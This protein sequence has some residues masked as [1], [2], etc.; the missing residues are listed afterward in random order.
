MRTYKFKLYNSDK[1]KYLSR[2]IDI[3]AFVWNHTVALQRKYYKLFGKYASAAKIQKHYTKLKKTG[4]YRFWD[5]LG[6]QA[7][8]EVVQRVDRSYRAFF[9]YKR[10]KTQLRKSPPKFKKKTRY[11]SFTLKQAGYKLD[12]TNSIV[13]INKKRYRYFNSRDIIGT[14]KTLTVKRTPLGEYF[15]TFVCDDSESYPLP[16]TGNAVGMDFGLKHFLTFSDGSTIDSP[17]WFKSSISE[18]RKANR[19]L[20]KCQPGSNHRKAALKQLERAHEAIAN[21]RKDWFFKLADKLTREYAAICIEDLNMK[22]MQKLWG[23]KIS[24]YAFSE[25]VSILEW[26]ALK[27]GCSVVKTDRWLPSSKACHVCGAV[28]ENL[29]LKDRIWVCGGCGTELDR[30]INAAINILNAGLS[31]VAV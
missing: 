6:S 31:M 14:I 30:D 23:R 3:A 8:Q 1:N 5:G 19:K 22:A 29:T 24:D 21:R 12:Q 17:Q 10:G 25:F 27:N 13:E 11:S 20:S 28:N 2:Q 16:R 9:D 18:I 15:V 26:E 7:I 4:K